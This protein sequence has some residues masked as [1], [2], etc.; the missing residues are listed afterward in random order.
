MMNH[1]EGNEQVNVWLRQRKIQ[2]TIGDLFDNHI[3]C[4]DC[5]QALLE[6]FNVSSSL[7]PSVRTLIAGAM[8][9]RKLNSSQKKDAIGAFLN[10]ITQ[11]AGVTVPWLSLVVLNGFARNVSAGKV[12]EI[13]GMVLD[14]HYGDLRL[15][16]AHVLYRI[17][18]ADAISYL[19]KAAKD[20]VTAPRALDGL[21][22]L[23]VEGTLELCEEAL[24]RKD[25]P[26]KDAIKETYGKLKRQLAKKKERYSHLTAE[27]IPSGI[28]EWSANFD[29]TELPRALRQ[30]QKLVK[31]GFSRNEIEEVVSAA[32]NLSV[33]RTVRLKFLITIKNDETALW[34]ELFCDDENAYDLYLFGPSELI[35]QIGNAY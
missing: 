21:A 9:D 29:G 23:R 13:G 16:L 1:D 32:N 7:P 28:G 17:G 26:Y 22:R 35:S 3:L 24:S 34:I 10:F 8:F 6:I 33:D 12:H 4:P 30:I 15:E 20:P 25:M 14:N 11:N 27:A 31:K 2:H 18:N 19:L 5:G